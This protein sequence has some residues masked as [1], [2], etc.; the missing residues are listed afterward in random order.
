MNLSV[1]LI[2]ELNDLTEEIKSLLDELEE[3]NS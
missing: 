2:D 1:V 3:L